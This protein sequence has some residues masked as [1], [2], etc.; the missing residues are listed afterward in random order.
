MRF[1]SKLKRYLKENINQMSINV[2]YDKKS[3]VIL[4]RQSWRFVKS[5][6]IQYKTNINEKKI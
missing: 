6:V 4:G 3:C 1:S 5:F 2:F